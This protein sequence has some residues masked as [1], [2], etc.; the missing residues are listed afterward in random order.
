MINEA[1]R[2]TAVANFASWLDQDFVSIDTE[3]NGFAK[4]SGVCELGVVGKDGST[5]MELL[6]KPEQPIP[7][8][9]FKIHGISNEDVAEAPTWSDIHEQF[10]QHIDGKLILIYNKP[11]D[12][13]LIHQSSGKGNDFLQA[14]NNQ[15]VCVMREYAK[16]KQTPS[17]RGGFKWWKLTEAAAEEG[18]V[19]E[20]DA[21]RAGYDCRLTI[22]LMKAV[23]KNYGA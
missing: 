4:T 18:V 12:V 16:I 23:V 9:A 10:C 17:N 20:G 19:L 5:L 21:H 6:I 11:F 13:R 2:Q 3:T 1:I 22:E 14:L 8:D 7:V 15:S